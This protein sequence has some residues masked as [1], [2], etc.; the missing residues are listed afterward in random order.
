MNM[1]T[2]A[3]IHAK[4]VLPALLVANI[5]EG[6]ATDKPAAAVVVGQFSDQD[7]VRPTAVEETET[8]Q[9]RAYA[10][11]ATEWTKAMTKRFRELTRKEAL[12]TI[13]ATELN[14]LEQ[15]TRDRRNL[16][17]P[18]PAE[19]VLWEVGQRQVTA[20]LVDA[21]RDYVEFHQAPREA[22]ASVR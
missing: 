12:G 8:R 13:A 3:R 6:S 7:G 10:E 5:A 14:E 4:A 15:L 1:T 19:E 2:I 11:T 22:R 16:E 9:T 20:K 21:L 17:Y 18:R